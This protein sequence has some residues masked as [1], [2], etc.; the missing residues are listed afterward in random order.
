M[1]ADI[2]FKAVLTSKVLTQDPV[3]G[4]CV[5]LDFSEYKPIPPPIITSTDESGIVREVAPII[6]QVIQSMPFTQKGMVKTPRFT[7]WLTKEEWN[8]LESKPDIGDEVTV[9]IRRGAFSINLK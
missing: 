8:S 9:V 7:L 6:Q 1:R 5:K 4:E 2:V 3:E